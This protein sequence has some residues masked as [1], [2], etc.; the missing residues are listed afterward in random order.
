MEALQVHTKRVM[1]VKYNSDND[2]CGPVWDYNFEV[3]EQTETSDDTDGSV[4]YYYVAY[5]DVL[6]LWFL[7]V[8]FVFATV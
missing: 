8:C 7:L 1:Q 6:V 3:M 5:G 2:T 4:W